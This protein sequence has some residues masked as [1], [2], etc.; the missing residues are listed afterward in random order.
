MV[1]TNI[2]EIISALV[3]P[4]NATYDRWMQWIDLSG[5]QR[6]LLCCYILESQQA[7]LLARNPRPS[8]VQLTGLDLPFPAHSALWEAAN[9]SDWAMASQQYS[10]LPTYVCDV[11]SEMSI[12]PYDCFQSSLL[13]AR[14]YNYFNNPTPYLGSPPLPAIDHL[15]D[16][17][18]VTKHQLLTAK[19]LQVT[20]IRALLAVS[21]ESWILSEKV[22]SPQ[23]FS[24]FKGTLR[25]WINGLWAPSNE[26]YNEAAKDALKLAIEI[27]QHA[28]EQ[29]A[30]DLCLDLGADMGLYF[31]SLVVWSV[32]VAANTRVNMPQAQAQALRYQSHSPLPSTQFPT[33]PTRLSANTTQLS[34]SPNPT[35]A[36]M[37]GLVPHSYT[38]PALSS[39]P[40]S[41]LHSEITI[42]SE[43]FL[44]NALLEL[45]FLGTVAQ[46]PR[47]VAQWQ[48][49]CGALM[50]WVKMRLRNGALEGRDSVVACGPTSAG[51]GRGGDGLGELLDGVIGVLEK[52]MR[53]GW[54]GWGV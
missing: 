44:S 40:T 1:A 3:R 54:E 19:L 20:P 4:E 10:H 25:S 2:V 22:P 46:W 42:T 49:G 29:P 9:P 16:A 12:G 34:T 48:Q 23:A 39:T 37:I 52:I 41:M 33:T 7:T 53:S 18:S 38:S 43:Y 11:N 45:D 24:A 14:Y 30:H 6:L 15:L 28:M 27:L 36:A 8:V 13:I 50:R 5:Q 32:T 21:G 17:S 31:A 26:A 35:H 47:D 51:T